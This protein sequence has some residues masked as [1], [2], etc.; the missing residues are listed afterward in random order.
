MNFRCPNT[1]VKGAV[2][3]RET[4]RAKRGSMLAHLSTFYFLLSTFCWRS[5]PVG[6]CL[7]P[8][9]KEENAKTVR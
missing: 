7:T 1:P 3:E 8:S 9:H 6:P 5:R 2:A 4:R